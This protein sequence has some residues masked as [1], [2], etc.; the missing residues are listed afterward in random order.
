M[1]R[2]PCSWIMAM[3]RFMRMPGPDRAGS[4]RAP[5]GGRRGCVTS[6]PTMT[7]M[8]RPRPSAMSRAASAASMR[9]WSVMAMASRPRATAASRMAS[10]SE[11]P[12]EASVW[13]CG[14]SRSVGSPSARADPE[15]RSLPPSGCCL[16]HRSPSSLQMGKNSVVHC[17]G[18]RAMMRSKARASCSMM[19]AHGLPARA[20][21]APGGWAPCGPATARGRCARWPRGRSA[22]PV[23]DGEHGRADGQS[24]R[25]AEELHA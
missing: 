14:S 15:A 10:T 23:C 20:G 16:A 24:R 25:R 13:M 17:S 19:V 2:P 12:S 22:R 5:R 6:S 1:A 18:A 7:S 21:P 8:G 3:E 11:T 4:S 9:S